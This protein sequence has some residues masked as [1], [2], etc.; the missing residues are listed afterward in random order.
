MSF[1]NW[2][3]ERLHPGLGQIQYRLLGIE[4]LN[5]RDAVPSQY[6]LPPK[7]IIA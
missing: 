1:S 6:K 4:N 7:G 3:I 5:S 2:L